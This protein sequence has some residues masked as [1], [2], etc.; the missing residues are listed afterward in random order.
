MTYW[1][2]VNVISCTCAFLLWQSDCLLEQRSAGE[3]FKCSYF[4][5][6]VTVSK[7]VVNHNNNGWYWSSVVEFMFS[8]LQPALFLW[9]VT[10]PCCPVGS[11]SNPQHPTSKLPQ[12]CDLDSF[13]ATLN[14]LTAVSTVLLLSHL[15]LKQILSCTLMYC[16]FISN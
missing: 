12:K 6:T 3:R 1:N 7:P 16:S 2:I 5:Q 14:R 4:L 13:S 9:P 10:Y 11:A 15:I 8:T